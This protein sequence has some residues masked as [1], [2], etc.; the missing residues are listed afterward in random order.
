MHP[1]PHGKA[2]GA[3]ARDE[4]AH[5]RA[6]KDVSCPGGLNLAA[7]RLGRAVSLSSIC[8]GYVMGR[9][10]EERERGVLLCIGGGVY[11]W[12]CVYRWFCVRVDKALCS[13]QQQGPEID[14][15]TDQLYYF[16]IKFE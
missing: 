1:P 16:Y 4:H 8:S 11:R 7:P 6:A 13:E 3:S 2:S 12:L 14:K 10:H 5:A 15:E 9:R